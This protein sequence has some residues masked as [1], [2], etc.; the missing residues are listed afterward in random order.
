[1]F[2]LVINLKLEGEIL[3]ESIIE[4]AKEKSSHQILANNDST[5]ECIDQND[6]G[7][8]EKLQVADEGEIFN[9]SEKGP[10]QTIL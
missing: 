10:T 7:M 3:K 6:T 4:K 1:M 8:S 5:S 2:G 9:D